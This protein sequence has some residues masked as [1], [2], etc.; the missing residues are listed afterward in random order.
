VLIEEEVL[1]QVMSISGRLYHAQNGSLYP[2]QKRSQNEPK[3]GQQR[4]MGSFWG[5]PFAIFFAILMISIT[6][7]VQPC[8]KSN[9]TEQRHSLWLE[10]FLVD[11][12]IVICKEAVVINA[13]HAS[14]G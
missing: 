3:L 10:P 1:L 6:L 4:E 5:V 13:I 8:R 11:V 2:G 12:V 7:P 9:G 14:R